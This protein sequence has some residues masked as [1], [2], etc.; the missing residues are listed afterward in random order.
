MLLP[1]AAPLPLRFAAPTL[2]RVDSAPLFLPPLFAP[3]GPSATDNF[4]SEA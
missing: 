3:F 2:I 4:D 1:S